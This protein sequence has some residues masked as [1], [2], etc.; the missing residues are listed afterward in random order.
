[1]AIQEIVVRKNEPDTRGQNLL[2][3]TTILGLP[4][5]TV[6]VTDVYRFEGIE[7]EQAQILADKLLANPLTQQFEINPE[8]PDQAQNITEVGYK[9][10]VL[11]P[12]VPSILRAANNLGINPLA[13]DVITRWALVGELT[14][15]QRLLITEKFLVNPTVQRVITEKPETL[16]ITG[17]V[18]PINIVPIR[19]ATEA[20][21]I[22][23][24]SDKLF[25]NL[26]EM[27]VI[28]NYFLELGR[29]PTD[30]ELE[31]LA[32]AWSEHCVHKTFKAK[33]IVD[34]VE[35]PP[36]IKRIFA[37]ALQH[38]EG[39]VS[40]FVDNSGVIVLN[41]KWGICGKGETH[42][43]PSALAPR[44]GAATGSGGVFRDIMGT[45]QGAK[46]IASTDIFCIAPPDLDPNELPAGTQHPL[47]MQTELVGG[48]AGYGNPSGIPTVNGAEV[49][50][51]AF[52]V[53]PTVIVGAYGL[54]P[55]EYAQKGEPR[56]ND[57][58]VVLGGRTGRDGIHGATF[59]SAEMTD[60]TATVNASAVQIGDPITQKR[61]SDALLEARDKGLIRAITD[62]GAA[63]FSS[64]I[65]EIGENTGVTVDISKA[66][67]KYAGL[68][69]WE[70]W[71]SESQERMVIAIDPNNTDQLMDICQRYD[72]EAT[73]LGTF[74]GS[75]KLTVKYGEQTVADLD[76]DFIK[77][78][79]PQRTMVAKWEKT[80]HDEPFP[81]MPTNWSDTLKKIL[82]HGN[83]CSKQPITQRYD[84]GVQG[85]VVIP[86][87]SGVHFDGPN[88]AA[89]FKPLPEEK[90]GVVLSNGLNP[91]LNDLDP[92]NGTIWAA[93]EAMANF[94]AVGGN[95]KRVGL[96]NNYISPV[97]TEHYMGALDKSVNGI[98]AFMHAIERPVVSGKDSLSSTYRGKDGTVIN[99]PPVVSISAFGPIEDTDYATTAD[100]KKPGSILCLVGDSTDRNMGGSVYF[101]TLGLKGN[102]VPVVNL[103]N[104]SNTLNSVH[105]AIQSGSV[106]ACHDI[107]EGGIITAVTEMSFGGDCGVD[108]NLDPTEQRPDILLFNEAPA[109]FII[110]VADEETALKLFGQTA[111]K[112]IGRTKV[113]KQITVNQGDNN[114]FDIN[115]DELK[116]A[117]KQPLGGIFN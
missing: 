90:Y 96:I 48:V 7:P 38:S 60:R 112:V 24:S 86:P 61:M 84:H 107:S 18:G 41:K 69:P 88:D 82:S 76:Y 55:L 113:R 95:P 22:E 93:A 26:D 99:I 35:K 73:V 78:G 94:V 103:Q 80:Y 75:H 65:G 100:I 3:Q 63:G 20:Q 13:A 57:L 2:H 37:A 58:V 27:K 36:L 111:Y 74:D 17:E 79:L 70:I 12:E 106:L 30:C 45:G 31:I 53:K 46:V 9:P 42:N 52:G 59:S 109:R 19:E 89:V 34:G 77:N 116:T 29:E 105:E 25:L 71:L 4:L 72:V 32:A 8:P 39:I 117:W 51:K 66:P 44:G 43:S 64:A 97:P 102:E 81:E 21:L 40:A 98:V 115:L 87:F 91:V 1:M 101:D 108:L 11:Q 10:G 56:V 6:E 54:I 68:A 15:E 67:L 92:Y 49:W 14:P 110:E 104:L 83:I 62:C 16:L 50:N 23:L 28:Q 85:G 5:T 33:V 114:L 47:Y